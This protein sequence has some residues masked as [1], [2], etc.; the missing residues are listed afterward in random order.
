[1]LLKRPP[2]SWSF[3]RFVSCPS[4]HG[5]SLGLFLVLTLV[6]CS[7]HPA[8]C[9]LGLRSAFRRPAPLPVSQAIEEGCSDDPPKVLFAVPSTLGFAKTSLRTPSAPTTRA[10]IPYVPPRPPRAKP[11]ASHLEPEKMAKLYALELRKGPL[12][13]DIPFHKRYPPPPPKP[14]PP[15][16]KPPAASPQPARPMSKGRTAAMQRRPI[17]DR[18]RLSPQ[19]VERQMPLSMQALSIPSRVLRVQ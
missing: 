7:N 12:P 8:L 17:I 10:S 11:I 6:P 16:P 2:P 4:N 13:Q 3:V 9:Q 1:M 5:L 18:P 15:P 19:I 14:P